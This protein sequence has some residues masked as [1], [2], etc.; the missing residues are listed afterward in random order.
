LSYAV[1]GEIN[2][3]PVAGISVAFTNMASVLIAAFLQPFIGWL[4]ELRWRGFYVDGHP[5]YSAG[6]YQSAMAMLPVTLVLAAIVALFIKET[7]CH[8]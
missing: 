4:L 1:A 6:D 3:K 8:N 2:P 7:Y 5:L